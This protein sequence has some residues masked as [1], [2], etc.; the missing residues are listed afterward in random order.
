MPKIRELSEGERAQIVLLH[1]LNMSQV[2]ITKQMKCSRYAVQLTL[3]RFKETGTYANKPRS[4][5]NR[6]TL[7]RE[8]RLL[9]RDSLRNR[10][11]TSV[12]LASDFNE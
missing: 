12:K 8:D 9:I 6:V 3:K 5:R 10:R 2:K 7:E 11:K 1:S 4:G